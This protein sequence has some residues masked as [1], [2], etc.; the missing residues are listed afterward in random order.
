[1]TVP[2]TAYGSLWCPR[3]K[4]NRSAFPLEVREEFAQ[5]VGE[6]ALRLPIHVL[7][8]A[9]LHRKQIRHR[10]IHNI[11]PLLGNLH[12]YHPTVRDIRKPDSKSVSDHP[13]NSIRDCS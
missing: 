6:L 2:Y 8:L 13:V 12:V 3:R 7:K 4:P 9:A 10:S 11:E 5:A 1:M